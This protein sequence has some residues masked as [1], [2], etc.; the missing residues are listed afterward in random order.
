MTLTTCHWFYNINN[1]SRIRYH[2]MH[3]T[4]FKT[5]TGCCLLDDINCIALDNIECISLNGWHFVHFF[6]LITLTACYWLEVIGRVSLIACHFDW[7]KFCS[8][9]VLLSFSL[10]VK[11]LLIF[12][13]SCIVVFVF[14]YIVGA[15][16]S[17]HVEWMC[18]SKMSIDLL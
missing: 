6:D 8:R 18:E 9:D 16:S 10:K 5:L 4:C 13:F 14:V 11:C 1:L 7:N 3:V 17:S 12:F 15:D 2:W